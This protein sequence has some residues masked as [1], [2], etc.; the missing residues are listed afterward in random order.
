M[1]EGPAWRRRQ[2]HQAA[3]A[4]TRQ[5]G[6]GQQ[7]ALATSKYLSYNSFL[8]QLLV[9]VVALWGRGEDVRLQLGEGE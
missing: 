5:A 1:A 4:L 9:Q 6:D 2:G 7:G 8:H 3:A